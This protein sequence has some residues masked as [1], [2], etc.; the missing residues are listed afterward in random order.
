MKN[1]LQIAC[2]AA[3]IVFGLV[4]VLL[5]KSLASTSAH[6]QRSEA[7]EAFSGRTWEYCALSK[8]AYVGSD[9]GGKGGLYWVSYFR[10]N[11]V[12]V[13]EYE[14]QA[15]EKNALAKAIAKLGADRWEMVGQGPLEIRVGTGLTVLYFKRPVS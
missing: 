8:S 5:L 11:G 9:K 7:R 3:L 14:D 13:V 2:G 15:T 1:K 4:N 10:E 12:Q 6:G